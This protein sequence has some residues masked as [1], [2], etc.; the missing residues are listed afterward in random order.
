MSIK[1][2]LLFLVLSS[3]LYFSQNREKIQEID[4]LINLAD[5]NIDV[6]F[7]KTLLF[8]EK[9]IT[10]A[11]KENDP[12]RIT[13][14]YFYAAKSL[15][16]FRRLEK[17]TQYIEEGLRVNALTNDVLLKSLFLSLK[18]SY[19]SRMSLFEESFQSK[20]KALKLIELNH[21]LESQLLIADLYISFA[22][23]YTDT[24]DFES[25][26]LYAD[27]SIDAIEKIPEQK[28]LSAKK[29]FREKPFIYFYKSWIL[30]QEKRPDEALP[31]IQKAYNN[32]IL[33]K[34]NYM[35]LFYE[36]Y[37]DYYFQTQAHPKAIEYYLKTVDNKEKFHQNHA[38]V[39]SKIAASY[40]ALG[41]YKNMS[42]YSERAGIR[43]ET[44]R[45]DDL[46]FV[47]NEF[48]QTLKKEKTDKINLQKKNF[49]T[50]LLVIFISVLLL[51]IVL[52]R[53]RKIRKRKRK[54]IQEQEYLLSEKKIEIKEREIEIE[55][56]QKDTFEEVLQLA[57]QNDPAF[58]ARFQEVYPEFC[59]NILELQ[60]DILTS[61]LILCAYLKLN[62][63]TKDIATYTF[64]TAK[65]I[66]NRKNRIRK[67]LNIPS[68]ADIYIWINDL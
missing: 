51:I 61:E 1:K 37:G 25:A 42:L 14:A 11:K 19:Y 27:K 21:D 24:N 62:F 52:L 22:D 10:K 38:L 43:L 57:K 4:S 3:N 48:N 53:S 26:H 54:I 55:K 30:L 67:R 16:F 41:D 40:K 45:K 68:D 59:N 64:V 29:I 2:L 13:K 46:E 12:E 34:Y 58:L 65:A 60:P 49:Y 28:Y 56:L 23:Y 7:D 39:D 66:Q 20:Q 31:F 44:D 8:A 9:A 5:Q 63:S 47:Q 17:S 50:I 32:A 33:E 15:V 18:G 6:D 35:A 36:I